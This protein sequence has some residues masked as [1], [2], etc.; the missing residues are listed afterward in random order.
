MLSHSGPEKYLA[1]FALGNIFCI[2]VNVIFN[3]NVNDCVN[4]TM[5]TGGRGDVG[6]ST[7]VVC[8]QLIPGCFAPMAYHPSSYQ[9]QILIASKSS[10]DH[11]CADTKPDRSIGNTVARNYSTIDSITKLRH[12]CTQI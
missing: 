8:C 11:L 2:T 7:V 6:N 9:V 12:T 4:T 5:R 1:P 3:I 10:Q